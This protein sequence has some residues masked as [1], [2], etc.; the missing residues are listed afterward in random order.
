MTALPAS[1]ETVEQI[2]Q[3]TTTKLRQEVLQAHPTIPQEDY[4]LLG[5]FLFFMG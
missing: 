4:F 3:Q 2:K 5:Y 1:T